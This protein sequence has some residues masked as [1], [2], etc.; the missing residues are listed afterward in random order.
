[1][2]EVQRNSILSTIKFS[3][4][5]SA[6][7]LNVTYSKRQ[8]VD[9]YCYFL[10]HDS[11]PSYPLTITSIVPYSAGAGSPT[12]SVQAPSI[13]SVFADDKYLLLKCDLH[14]NPTLPCAVEISGS[15]TPIGWSQECVQP[16]DQSFL[17]Y[18][19]NTDCHGG[20][21]CVSASPLTAWTLD[22]TTT[23]VLS[24]VNGNCDCTGGCPSNCALSTDTATVPAPAPIGPGY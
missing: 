24:N 12:C 14:T 2:S 18:S 19:P 16:V 7:L 22:S 20:C 15:W 23:N 3:N 10:F 11:T 1:M 5:N 21:S 4:P 13:Y 17:N 6:K 8:P 9:D